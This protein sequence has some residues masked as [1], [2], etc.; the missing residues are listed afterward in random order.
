[1]N[2]FEKDVQSKGNDALESGAGFVW[3][4]LFFSIIFFVAVIIKAVN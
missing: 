1:M 2:E 4:F 3:S